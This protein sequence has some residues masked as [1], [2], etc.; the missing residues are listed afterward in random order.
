MEGG[1]KEKKKEGDDDLEKWWRNWDISC[2]RCQFVRSL[3]PFLR[4]TTSS[5]PKLWISHIAQKQRKPK[6]KSNYDPFKRQNRLLNRIIHAIITSLQSCLKWSQNSP[7]YRAWQEIKLSTKTCHPPLWTTRLF[8][9]VD[10][11]TAMRNKVERLKVV[12]VCVCRVGQIHSFIDHPIFICICP[13][14]ISIHMHFYLSSIHMY[15]HLS[16]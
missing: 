14:S 8:I 7:V 6:P 16:T 9:S 3:K 12:C 4:E 1:A 13:S 15:S 10:N 2:S 5:R 11:L